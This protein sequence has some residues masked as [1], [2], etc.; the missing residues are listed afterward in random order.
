MVIPRRL[1]DPDGNR[2]TQYQLSAE[3]KHLRSLL[4]ADEVHEVA[5]SPSAVFSSY[6]D[7][8]LVTGVEVQIVDGSGRHPFPVR[9]PILLDTDNIAMSTPNPE[10]EDPGRYSARGKWDDAQAARR[11]RLLHV[12]E[13]PRDHGVRRL[14]GPG[15]V[16]LGRTTRIHRLG[17]HRGDGPP[18]RQQNLRPVQG[19]R[20]RRHAAM[21]RVARGGLVMGLIQT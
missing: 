17:L 12:R 11:Q 13:L 8:F 6:S 19:D 5:A 15:H 16:Q 3:I 10:D 18:V 1:L 14:G 21:G 4:V 7:N 9:H 2:W 20:G